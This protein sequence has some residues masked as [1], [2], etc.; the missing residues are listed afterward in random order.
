MVT[1]IE[2]G[3]SW[4][5]WSGRLWCVR[6]P[7][8]ISVRDLGRELDWAVRPPPPQSVRTQCSDEAL[9][10]LV[11]QE[12][13]LFEADDQRQGAADGR[14]AVV[15]TAALTLT[16]LSL[17]AWDNV[18]AASR[19]AKLGFAAVALIT[20]GLALLRA[21]SGY[22]HRGDTWFSTHSK[23][24][25]DALRA[26]R[27]HEAEIV[28]SIAAASTERWRWWRLEKRPEAGR[29]DYAAKLFGLN[30]RE[31]ALAVWRGRAIDARE[32]AKRKERAA[33]FAAVLLAGVLFVFCCA[34]AIDAFS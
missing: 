30:D 4:A 9:D 3:G 24:T 22:F 13:K 6:A 34:A 17:T 8:L 10:R 21:G 18:A 29:E 19:G 12:R 20:A 5:W 15:L 32:R 25:S 7:G 1:V 14:T 27:S 11:E 26:L 16:G 33:G 23:D 2:C 31:L 28:P